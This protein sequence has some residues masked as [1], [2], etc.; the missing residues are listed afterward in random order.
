[1]H[2]YQYHVP[3]VGIWCADWICNIDTHSSCTPISTMYPGWGYSVHAH[4]MTAVVAICADWIC[5]TD[6]HNVSCTP[7]SI[8][9]PA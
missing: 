8:M 6:T 7:I 4:R 3:K 9:Y 1:M 2:P 5:N